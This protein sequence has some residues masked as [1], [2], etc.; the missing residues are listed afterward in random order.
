MLHVLAVVLGH[1]PV[2]DC[3]A[4]W[5]WLCF[6]LLSVSALFFF[7]ITSVAVRTVLDLVAITV[8]DLSSVFCIYISA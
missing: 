1:P 4:P 3:S 7:L 5:L 6:F 8:T 2:G